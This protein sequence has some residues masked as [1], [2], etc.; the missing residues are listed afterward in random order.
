MAK[1]ESK[2]API[3]ENLEF[4]NKVE[5]TDPQYAK[6][7]TNSAYGAKAIDPQYQ[8]YTAT[9]EWGKCG[10]SWGLKNVDYKEIDVANGQVVLRCKAT[11]FYPGGEIEIAHAGMLVRK[12]QH[13]LRV[14]T[15]AYKKVLTSCRSKALSFLGFNADVFMGKFEDVDYVKQLHEE[16]AQEVVTE[17]NVRNV[18]ADLLNKVSKAIADSH[19][20]QRL[21]AYQKK[22]KSEI[23]SY[24]IIRQLFDNKRSLLAQIP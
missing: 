1:A 16:K 18:P 7:I 22:Y 8:I 23:T 19:D 11:F 6:D 2:A 24:P 20:E 9:K 3:V 4:W 21:D 17:A 14:D 10:E 13:G 15:D 12:S 5:K